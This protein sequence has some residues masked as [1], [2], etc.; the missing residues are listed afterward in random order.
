MSN[1]WLHCMLFLIQAC[2]LIMLALLH[3]L[4]RRLHGLVLER[5]FQDTLDGVMARAAA[6]GA[7]G[8][9]T[10]RYVQDAPFVV[11]AGA[12]LRTVRVSMGMHASSTALPPRLPTCSCDAVNIR[13]RF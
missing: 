8:S 3:A 12:E 7:L 1:P 2:C 10:T 6:A 11:P 4:P 9:S 5:Y 13:S